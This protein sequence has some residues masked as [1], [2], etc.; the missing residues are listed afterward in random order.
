[1]NVKH[2][3]IVLVGV[4]LV[5]TMSSLSRA[6]LELPELG[7]RMSELSH[8]IP[9]PAFV[10]EDIDEVS[11][12]FTNYKGKV[13]LIN[14]WATWCP[15][16]RREM[17]SMERLQQKFIKKEFAILAINQMEDSE[18]VFTFTGQLSENPTFPILFDRKSET[19]KKYDVKGLPTTYLI[20]KSGYIRYRAIGGREFDHPEIEK[21]ILKLLNE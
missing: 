7:Y 13:V 11:V 20:D 4:L 3:V 17:P 1:M 15:P 18:T 21:I 12:D 10:L 14:F 6:A 19:S 5:C 16:C 2:F 8:P 9:A